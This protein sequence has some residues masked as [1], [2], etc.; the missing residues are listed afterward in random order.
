[1]MDSFSNTSIR[2]SYINTNIDNFIEKDYDREINPI[3]AIHPG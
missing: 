3:S 1:M 2:T